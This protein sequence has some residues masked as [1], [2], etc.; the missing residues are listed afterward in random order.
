M[1]GLVFTEYMEFVEEIFSADIVDEMIEVAELPSQGAYTA[2]GTYRHVELLALVTSLSQLTDTPV[3]RLV[4]T[5][6]KHLF[7]RLAAGH[8]DFIKGVDNSFDFLQ[9]VENHIHVEVRKLY[10]DAELP[11]LEDQRPGPDHLILTYSSK[12]PFG[13]LAMGL[14]EG[15]IDHFSEQVTITRRD[16]ESAEGYVIEFDLVKGS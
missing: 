2:V 5:F 3:S 9:L 11:Q 4:Q 8:P 6:G 12:R 10:P 13:D 15:C 14:I 7:G 1:K 16:I